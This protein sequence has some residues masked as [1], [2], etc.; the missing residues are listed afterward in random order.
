MGWSTTWSSASGCSS[1]A[2][3][4]ALRARVKAELEQTLQRQDNLDLREREETASGGVVQANIN[5]N[6]QVMAMFSGLFLVVALV[7]TFI[8]LGQFVG[9]ERQRIGTL[10][11]LG[12]SRRELV[13]H[14]LT[15]G[16]LIGITGGLVGSVLGYFASFITM[17]PFV[18]AIAGG[19]LPGFANTP[20]IPFILLGF[21][22]VVVGTTLAGAYPAWAESGT[23]PGLPCARPRRVRPARS[24]ACR[25]AF[26]R[27]SCARPCA[28]SCARRD[29]RSPPPWA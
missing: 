17:Y 1:A 18:D 4:S 16:L 9:S 11:A 2:D 25:W 12:V 29:A 6:F 10:R 21:G 24:A 8:L 3:S 26:C 15:F 22:L 28:T 5:G 27:S 13:A 23:P 7:V 20:Q 19:Y 14:Y